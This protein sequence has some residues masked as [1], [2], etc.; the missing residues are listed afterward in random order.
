MAP[1]GAPGR[2]CLQGQG[3][4]WDTATTVLKYDQLLVQGCLR[5]MLAPTC[6][7]RLVLQRGARAGTRSWGEE[8]IRPLAVSALWYCSTTRLGTDFLMSDMPL[9]QLSF[10]AFTG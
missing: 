2:S 10:T 9:P 4:G 6:H 8:Q 1:D 3:A 5:G 7:Q